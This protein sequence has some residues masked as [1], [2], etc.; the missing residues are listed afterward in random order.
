MRNNT[1]EIHNLSLNIKVISDFVFK[2]WLIA[3]IGRNYFR[4]SLLKK[5][6]TI[7]FKMSA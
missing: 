4:D 7:R 2:Y 3:W 5:K 6:L 1:F